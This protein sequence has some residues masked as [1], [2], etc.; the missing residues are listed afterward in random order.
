M[1][2]ADLATLAKLPISLLATLA[3]ATGFLAFA[4]EP[5]PPLAATLAGTL[6]LAAGAAALNQLLERGAD[7][8]MERTR[9]RPIPAG[10]I[11]A[12][13]AALL[14]CLAALAGALLLSRGAGP[15]PAL[16]GLAALAWY[17]A[18]YTPLK[19]RTAFAFLPGALVGALPPAIGWAA[20]GGSLAD[21]R[22]HALCAFFLL[23]QVPHSWLVALRHGEDLERGGFP[24]PA[25][26]F[27]RGQGA[28][29]TFAWAAAS[30]GAALLLPVFGVVR[31]PAAAFGLAGAAALLLVATAAALRA[32]AGGAGGRRASIAVDLLAV[33]AMA[34]VAGD[35]LLGP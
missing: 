29:I 31:T 6:L 5:R 21:G 18:V 12:G 15:L 23:W 28:R 32:A 22:L 27:S 17:V 35:A 30:A 10:R 24:S 16:L 25:R 26:R 20:A 4:R 19:R 11:A 2:P 13:P 33:A 1:T 7:A 34:V 14:A 9:D 3:A 8:R